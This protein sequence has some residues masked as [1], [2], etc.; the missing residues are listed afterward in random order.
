MSDNIAKQTCPIAIKDGV[1]RPVINFN[2]ESSQHVEGWVETY[3]D[4]RAKCPLAW[5]EEHG[6]YW[7]ATRYADILAIAQNLGS[8]E[9]T[10]TLDAETGKVKGGASIPAVA[11]MPRGIPN[12]T[13]SP[14]W[15]GFRRFLNPMFS[16]KAVETRRAQTQHFAAALIDLVIEKGEMD[17][18]EDLTNPLPALTTMATFGLPLS[19]WRRF[20]DPMHR[21]NYAQKG[22]PDLDRA[23]TCPIRVVHRLSYNSGEHGRPGGL[24]GAERRADQQGEAR[25]LLGLVN[26]SPASCA[27]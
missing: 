9:V 18:V 12:E 5:T 26:D 16:P 19:E 21:V 10:K 6:G 8:F 17:L 11:A 14:E 3:K 1:P 15:D 25:S 27:A 4:I 13:D 20:A 23:L 2:H 7:V 24:T 22:S